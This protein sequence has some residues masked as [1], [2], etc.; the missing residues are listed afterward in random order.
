MNR[1][2]AALGLANRCLTKP[3]PFSW[4]DLPMPQTQCSNTHGISGHPHSERATRAMKERAIWL[5]GVAVGG[6]EQAWEATG[7]RND[8]AIKHRSHTRF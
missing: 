6:C 8:I 1:C 4:R 3:L 2:G 7:H 5:S